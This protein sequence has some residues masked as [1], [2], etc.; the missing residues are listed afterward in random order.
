MWLKN[1]LTNVQVVAVIDNQF[2]DTGKGKIVDVLTTWADVTARGTGGHPA[3]HTIVIGGKSRIFHLIPAGIINDSRGGITILGN[4]MVISPE[5]LCKELD[6]LDQEGL[7]YNHLMISQ[8]AH[9]IM[10]YH[11]TRDKMAFQKEIGTTGNGIGPCYSDKTAR[12]GIMVRDLFDNDVLRNKI[13]K[14]KMLYPEQNIDSEEIIRN[15]KPYIERIKPFVKD[16]VLEIHKLHSQGKKILIEGAQGL[17]LSVEH[18]T[19]P[20]VTSSDCSLNGT[21]SGVGLSAHEVDLPL[22]LIKF[23][24]M[25]RVGEGPFP[26]EIGKGH[27]A[28][29]KVEELKARSIPFKEEN[30]KVSYNP[31][32]PKIIQMMKSSDE[33][34]KSVGMR[35][36]A[37]EFGAT[38]GRPRRVGWT[39]AVAARYAVKINGPNFVLTKPDSLSDTGDFKIAYGYKINGRV[40]DEFSNDVNILNKVSPVYKTYKGYGSLKGIQNLRELPKSLQ[41]AVKDFEQ[42]TGGRVRMISTGP[43]RDETIVVN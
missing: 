38:T 27:L 29:R 1:L 26:T 22:G 19:Y 12:Q 9:V 6:M 7:S 31:H 13:S 30:D 42:F 24:F 28:S 5:A 17:L 18:G 23:P 20:Y 3:G 16:T 37:G 10:P 39:D 32:D 14:I 8:H 43:E 40:V 15:L 2:G 4:G 36:I 35:L 33:K 11:V 21:V 25:S 34:I 41:E